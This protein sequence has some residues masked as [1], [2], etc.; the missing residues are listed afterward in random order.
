[1]IDREANAATGASIDN[2]VEFDS[3]RAPARAGNH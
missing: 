1:M 3:V 2:T